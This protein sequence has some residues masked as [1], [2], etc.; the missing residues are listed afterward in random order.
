MV[1]FLKQLPVIAIAVGL[2]LAA[3]PLFWYLQVTGDRP[4]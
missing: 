1:E 2:C 3:G 4:D